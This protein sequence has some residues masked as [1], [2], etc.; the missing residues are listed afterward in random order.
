MTNSE[1]PNRVRPALLPDSRRAT[2]GTNNCR[3]LVG[4]PTADSL[5]VVDAFSRII[6]LGEGASQLIDHS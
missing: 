3:L 2:R 5:R 1:W 6:R 4:R